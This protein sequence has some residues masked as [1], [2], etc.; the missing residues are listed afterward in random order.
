MTSLDFLVPGRDGAVARSPMERPQAA[1]PRAFRP[2]SVARTPG[3][4]LR[5]NGDRFLMLFGWALGQYM[6]ETVADAAWRL[7][8]G[9][10]GAD[11]LVPIEEELARA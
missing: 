5:E 8:G 9:P 3:F 7:G 10:V 11:A 1:P 6:W 2:A 4:V